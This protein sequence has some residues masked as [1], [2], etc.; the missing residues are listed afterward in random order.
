MGMW[1]RREYAFGKESMR[2]D[3]YSASFDVKKFWIG[4]HYALIALKCKLKSGSC[5]ITAITRALDFWRQDEQ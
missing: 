5:D 3:E 2:E 1:K 4:Y